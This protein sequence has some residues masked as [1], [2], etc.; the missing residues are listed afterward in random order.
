M[1]VTGYY[2][3]PEEFA[4]VV[5]SVLDQTGYFKRGLPSH[6]ED[7]VIAFTT[8]AE[9]VAAGMGYIIRKRLG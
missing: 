9:A 8:T 7:I 5:V 2:V 6:P 1:S 3:T 4:E